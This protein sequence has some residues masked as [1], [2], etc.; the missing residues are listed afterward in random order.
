ME[1]KAVLCVVQHVWGVVGFAVA[2]M[3]CLVRGAVAE[4]LESGH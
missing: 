4:G 1:V 2:V 3:S